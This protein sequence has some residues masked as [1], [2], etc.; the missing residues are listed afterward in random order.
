MPVVPGRCHGHTCHKSL[1]A[2]WHKVELSCAT[3]SSRSHYTALLFVRQALNNSRCPTAVGG[4]IISAYIS[5]GLLSSAKA[6]SSL[7]VFLCSDGVGGMEMLT[8]ALLFLSFE[9]S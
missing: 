7:A 5:K 3:I 9:L 8:S 1:A 6:T 2:A 4:F